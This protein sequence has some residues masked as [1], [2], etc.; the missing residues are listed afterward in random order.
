MSGPKFPEIHAEHRRCEGKGKEEERQ[1][2]HSLQTLCLVASYSCLVELRSVDHEGDAFQALASQSLCPAFQALQVKSDIAHSGGDSMD[3]RL[4]G[5]S[6][7]F[8]ITPELHERESI[9]NMKR[10]LFY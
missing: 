10:M 9:V 3:L 4:L 8:G 1:D 2:R 6:W 5:G 7:P